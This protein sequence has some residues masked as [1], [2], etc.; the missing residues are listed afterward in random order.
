MGVPFGSW[1]LLLFLLLQVNMGI[2]ER[3]FAYIIK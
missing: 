2:R 1:L 3:F